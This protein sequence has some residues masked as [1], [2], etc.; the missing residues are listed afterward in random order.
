MEVRRT[1]RVGEAF[2]L[3]ADELEREQQAVPPFWQRTPEES[4]RRRLREVGVVVVLSF[5]ALVIG[6]AWMT[7]WE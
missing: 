1:D 7:L 6:V 3:M 5:L 4:T 2:R